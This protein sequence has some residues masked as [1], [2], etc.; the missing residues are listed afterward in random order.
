MHQRETRS[1]PNHGKRCGELNPLERPSAVCLAEANF[2]TPARPL[3]QA[4]A[5]NDAE[6]VS[7]NAREAAAEEAA[8]EGGSE[9]WYIRERLGGSG[10]AG[11]ML[12]CLD[13]EEHDVFTDHGGNAA[14]V[15][16]ATT[17]GLQVR[18]AV[19]NHLSLRWRSEHKTSECKCELD[20]S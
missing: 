18:L 1:H 3:L 4:L 5:D 10:G 17:L 20:L 9:S 8:G 11:S 14:V 12:H 6:L 19:G 16:A 2:A 13:N 15:A 7:L